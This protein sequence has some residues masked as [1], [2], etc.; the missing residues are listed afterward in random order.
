MKSL[1]E[2]LL[3]FF[4]FC[5]LDLLSDGLLPCELPLVS[6]GLA[7]PIAA[8]SWGAPE[9]A[10]ASMMALSNEVLRIVPPVLAAWFRGLWDVPMYPQESSFYD[11]IPRD[12]SCEV[13][14]GMGFRPA[15]TGKLPF[16]PAGRLRHLRDQ[17]KVDRGWAA[18]RITR[19]SRR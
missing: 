19:I 17:R 7:P 4:F 10:A 12:S 2:L 13:P 15:N 16:L 6:L 3:S 9:M 11:F 14:D 18:G 1:A 5:L 8:A